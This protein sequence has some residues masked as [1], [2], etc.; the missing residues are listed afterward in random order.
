MKNK[1]L[2]IIVL[3]LFL[4]FGCV[5]STEKRELGWESDTTISFLNEDSSFATSDSLYYLDKPT[6]S[7][8]SVKTLPEFDT[9]I[10]DSLSP[11]IKQSL[12]VIEYQQKQIDSLLKARKEK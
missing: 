4:L 3:I 6:E 2:L 7:E 9:I 11:D 5:S 8:F 12:E 10:I 1:I